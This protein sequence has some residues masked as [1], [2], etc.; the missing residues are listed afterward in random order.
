MAGEALPKEQPPLKPE[1]KRKFEV[2]EGGKKKEKK[3]AAVGGAG[4]WWRRLPWYGK[5]TVIAGPLLGG[6]AVVGGLEAAGVIDVFPEEQKGGDQITQDEQGNPVAV[7]TI[8]TTKETAPER[9]APTET[10]TQETTQS[11][12]EVVETGP[13][14]YEGVTIN[15]IE[16]LRFDNGTFFAEAGNPYGLEAETKAGVFIKDAFEFNGQME[17]SIALRPEVIEYLQKNIMEKDKE[18]RFPLP[19]DLQI[20]KQLRI[21]ELNSLKTDETFWNEPKALA[22][23]NIPEGAKIFAPLSTDAGAVVRNGEINCGWYGFWLFAKN[24]FAEGAFFN[25]LYFKG[26]RVDMASIELY[27]IGVKIPEE[28]EA[29][30]PPDAEVPAASL[31]PK[32]GLPIASIVRQEAL[33]LDIYR[34]EKKEEENQPALDYSVIINFTMDQFDLE[35]AENNYPLVGTY[36]SGGDNL[37]KS[38]DFIVSIMPAND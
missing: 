8:E 15:P 32:I 29:K 33:N 31:Q 16:G 7:I 9:T 19:F 1:P 12:T 24:S 5:A 26:E 4:G 10:T 20:A 2:V 22:I 37:L 23:S 3:A 21:D 13:I 11:T 6:G 38:G 30:I 14:E 17:N 25:E 18:F 35:D 34:L 36:Q 27:A 28:M